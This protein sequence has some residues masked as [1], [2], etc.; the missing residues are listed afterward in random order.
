MRLLDNELVIEEDSFED[1]EEVIVTKKRFEM[2]IVDINVEG[3][4]LK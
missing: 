4:K 3:S 2:I 1:N